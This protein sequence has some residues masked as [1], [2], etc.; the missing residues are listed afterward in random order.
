MKTLLSSDRPLQPAAR[1]FLSEQIVPGS[2][3]GFHL[4]QINLSHVT[5][6]PRRRASAP[7]ASLDPDNPLTSDAHDGSSVGA[8][9]LA[10]FPLPS[11]LSDEV[12]TRSLRGGGH[13]WRPAAPAL[14]ALFD[15][16]AELESE[17]LRKSDP[18]NKTALCLG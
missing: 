15:L 1:R 18:R 3:D 17:R 9:A 12:A 6:P 7:P 13:R 14:T 8:A 2:A 11:E 10:S 4:N 16:S 5:P